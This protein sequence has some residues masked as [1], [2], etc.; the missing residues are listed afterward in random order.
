LLHNAESIMRAVCWD[1]VEV[2][3][4][5]AATSLLLLPLLLCMQ[6][7]PSLYALW[8]DGSCAA[9]RLQGKVNTQHQRVYNA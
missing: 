5:A 1:A 4:A 8:P 9:I 7:H 6:R 3:A 2:T